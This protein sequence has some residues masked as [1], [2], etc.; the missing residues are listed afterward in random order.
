MVDQELVTRVEGAMARHTELQVDAFVGCYPTAGASSRSIDGGVLA[1]LGVGRYVNRGVGIGLGG[2]PGDELI[3]E[4]EQFYTARGLPSSLEV[5]PWVPPAAIDELRARGYVVSWFRNVYAHDLLELP[6]VTRVQIEQVDDA[7]E[8][9]WTAILGGTAGAD[10]VA[11]AVSDEFCR[12]VR[13]VPGATDHVAFVDDRPAASGSVTFVDDLA[14]FGGA[15]TLA[16]ARSQGLQ[17]ALLGHRLWQASTQGCRL[18]LATAVPQG[19]SARNLLRA[20]FQLLYTQAVM[21]RP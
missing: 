2:M 21:T 7:L 8:P 3:N 4:V 9:A 6:L 11:R 16:D 12:A 10:T 13:R 15:A 18:A 1:A 17:Q 19:S 14:I 20:G 5:S